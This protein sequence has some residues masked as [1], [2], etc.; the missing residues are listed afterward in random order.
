MVRRYLKKDES[1][2]LTVDLLKVFVKKFVNR[3]TQS[4]VYAE[5]LEEVQPFFQQWVTNN[6]LQQNKDDVIEI[7]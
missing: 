6:I 3:D 4:S 1:T 7:D 2:P 5:L